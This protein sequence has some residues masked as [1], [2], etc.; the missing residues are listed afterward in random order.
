MRI[1]LAALLLG[2]GPAVA[3]AQGAELPGGCTEQG[4]NGMVTAVL[5]PAGLAAEDWR[6]AGDAACNGRLPCGAWIWDDAAH[7]PA[8]LPDSH[9]ALGVEAI[10]A[11]VA[12]WVAEDQSLITLERVTD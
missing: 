2:L 4:S 12:I 5:C 9:D 10:T 1:A 11:A 3:H 8:P 7:V 6:A